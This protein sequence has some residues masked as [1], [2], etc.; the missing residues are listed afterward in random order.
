M[1]DGTELLCIGSESYNRCIDKTIKKDIAQR[2]DFLKE[3]RIFSRMTNTQLERLLFF[4]EPMKVE[5]GKTL[6]KVGDPSTGIYLIKS[7]SFEIT[8]PSTLTQATE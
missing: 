1:D 7:G 8:I 2:V 6:Y 3:I 4:L 5:Y